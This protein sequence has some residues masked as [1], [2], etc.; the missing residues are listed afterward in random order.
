MGKNFPLGGGAFV[1][2]FFRGRFPKFS[3]LGERGGG[4][5]NYTISKSF[6]GVCLGRV[7]ALRID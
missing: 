6:L 7:F 3:R 5:G 4:A 1:Q 2:L